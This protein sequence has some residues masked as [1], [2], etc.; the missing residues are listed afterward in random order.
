MIKLFQKKST[1][2]ENECI[3][4]YDKKKAKKDFEKRKVVFENL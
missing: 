2:L 3:R 1:K 4:G